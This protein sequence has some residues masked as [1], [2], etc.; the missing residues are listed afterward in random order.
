MEHHF[1]TEIAKVFGVHEAV[2]IHNLYFWILK[3]QCNGR[4]FYEGRNW[5]YNSL[6]ALEKLF[7]YFSRGQIRR[8]ID[9]CVNN[10]AVLKGNFN[11]AGYDKTNWFSLTDEVLKAYGGYV[12]SNMGC[13]DISTG[14]AETDISYAENNPTIPDNKPYIKPDNKH[15]ERKRF[16]PPSLAEVTEYC[17]E[18]SNK[19]SPQQFIDF[20]ESKGWMVGK[21]KMKDWKASVRTWENRDKAKEQQK[22]SKSLD[23]PQRI[24]APGEL[25]EGLYDVLA[26]MEDE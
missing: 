10:G 20:Y 9:N 19:V 14:Y 24:Y 15:R 12:E 6:T 1:N 16:S 17:N 26:E 23:Y 2:F 8:L 21:D 5:T 22:V 3:N 4:H 7:P 18:R 11:K 13:V 25:E